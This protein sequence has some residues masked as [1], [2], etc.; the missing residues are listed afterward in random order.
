MKRDNEQLA[1]NGLTTK[2]IEN[3]FHL[4]PKIA[5]ILIN[6][7]F[8]E[9]EA[10]HQY[11]HGGLSYLHP[12]EKMPH[13]LEI[14]ERI[15]ARALEGDRIAIYSDYDVD[16][17]T[18]AALLYIGLEELSKTPPLL[19]PSHRFNDGYG[20]SLLAIEELSKAGAELL[21]TVDC[22]ISN[23]QEIEAAKERGM[24]VIVIDH[25]ES[26]DPPDTL[27]LDLKVRNGLYPFKNLC[28][29]ALCW[30]LL[31]LILEDPLEDLLDLVAL[32]TIADV[33][34]LKEENRIIVKEGLKNLMEGKGNLGLKEILQLKGLANED[35][36]PHHIGF[37][38]APLL[39][40]PGRLG[41]PQMTLD[42]LLT[43]SPSKRR[44]LAI[45]L[46][47]MNEKRRSMTKKAI[48][49]A[50]GRVDARDQIILYQGEIEAG[51]LGLV[52]S[53]IREIYNKPAIII[54]EGH[55]GSAR[56]VKPFNI[57]ELLRDCQE[58]LLKYGGHRM[59]AGF[60]LKEGAFLPFKE[61]LL[62]LTKDIESQELRAD[63]EVPLEELDDK[64]LEDVKKMEPFGSGNPRP[65]FCARNAR[66]QG[67]RILPGGHL[68][69]AVE[70]KR[71]I[72]YTMKD[73]APL[74]REGPMDLYYYPPLTANESIVLKDL[75]PSSLANLHL[76]HRA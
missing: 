12:P 14:A 51:I 18:G 13:I 35:L 65:L 62:E 10:I 69:F 11:L 29:A 8:V 23:H 37:Q 28:G 19:R 59:A 32:A 38:V 68:S 27:Y 31:Q 33:V 3:L 22:G 60:T 42:A 74:C 49:G 34:E 72:G 70:D 53:E 76:N 45:A 61:R 48:E 9:E 55:R 20:L 66:A 36:K 5:Q 26:S 52:A 21:L 16:G 7:G 71:A 40:A 25:H 43:P 17:L 41:S 67:I 56:S 30:K 47:Q 39:N 24:E 1:L 75:R 44:E 73:K 54:G 57:Y 15:K 50:R 46:N 64:L 63:L 2:E 4:H 6:R 58:F